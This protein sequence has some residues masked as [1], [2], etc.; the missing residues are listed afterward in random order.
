[1]QEKPQHLKIKKSERAQGMA[2]FGISLVILLILVAGIVDLGRAFFTLVTLH[3]AVQEGV[4]YGQICP[5]DEAGIEARLQESASDPVDLGDI[6]LGDINVCISAPGS[7]TC[8]ASIQTGNEITVSAALQH[9][10][11][12]PF[13]GTFIGSQSFVLRTSA[14][15]KILR[16]DCSTQ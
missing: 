4:T 15:D 13:L 2:E 12:T 16:T 11:S 10:I 7:E 5:D 9:N 8:G 1:M 3:D 14:R 6:P